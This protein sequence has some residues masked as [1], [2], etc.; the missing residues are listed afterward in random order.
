VAQRNGDGTARERAARQAV[1]FD[2]G[3]V[4]THTSFGGLEA[5][6]AGLG[7]PDG[8]LTGYFRGHPEM[9]KLETA[10]ITSREFFKFVCVDTEQRT[11]T[12]LNI[13][14]LAA[15]AARGEELNPAM[16]ELV[17]DVHRGCV[18]ALLTNNVAEAGWR[19]GF[20][21]DLFDVVIDSSQVGLRKPDPQMYRELLGR[22]GLPAAAVTFIDDLPENL[23]PAADLGIR[24][25]LFGGADSLRATLGE[26]GALADAP[27][28]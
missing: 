24:T 10:Q 20:P 1:A 9:T 15:A 3:G 18:T 28:R 22:I 16:V 27:S 17:E 25:I 14:E 2:M 8:L 12:R 5:Y 13:R 7:L 6:A 21:F 19:A 26:L 4:L 23:A 11:G